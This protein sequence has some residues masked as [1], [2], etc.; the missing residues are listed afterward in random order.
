ME[1][2][3]YLFASSRKMQQDRSRYVRE[4][5]NTW[6]QNLS[7]NEMLFAPYNNLFPK[8]SGQEPEH[9]TTIPIESDTP[10]NKAKTTSDEA[11]SIMYID[12][13]F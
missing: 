13:A 3:Y 11:V 7:Q 5:Q 9:A 1:P 8:M 12:I 10:A 4:H 6:N 2:L